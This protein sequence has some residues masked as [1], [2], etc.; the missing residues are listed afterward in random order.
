MF[1]KQLVSKICPICEEKKSRLLQAAGVYSIIRCNNCGLSYIDPFPEKAKHVKFHNSQYFQNYYGTSIGDFY[2]NKGRA[3]QEEMQIKNSRLSYVSRFCKTGKIL[4]VGTGQGLFSVAAKQRGWDT[5]ATDISSYVCEFLSKNKDIKMFNGYLE[6]A[7]FP[8]NYFDVVTIWHVLEH[9]YDPFVT[10]SKIKK[11]LKVGGHLFIAIPN[12][13]IIE[14]YLRKFFNKPHFREDAD[15]WHFYSFNPKSLKILLDRLNFQVED[16][17]SE[18]YLKSNKIDMPYNRISEILLRL[19]GI[20][21]CRTM[22]IHAV[23]NGDGVRED[24]K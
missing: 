19:C 23:K 4:D 2:I 20:N 16:F 5:Y 17:G 1:K 12:T 7:D 6:E 21:I 9:T 10:L 11:L 8:E 14:T 22:L 13:L 18:Y 15:E 3:F 24:E